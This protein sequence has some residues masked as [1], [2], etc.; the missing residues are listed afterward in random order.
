M[1]IVEKL[2]PS[3]AQIAIS[4]LYYETG[5]DGDSLWWRQRIMARNKKQVGNF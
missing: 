2:P 5:K 3:T 4:A 1:H